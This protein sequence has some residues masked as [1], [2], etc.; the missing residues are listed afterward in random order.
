MYINRYLRHQQEQ[1]ASSEAAG[2]EG[3]EGTASEAEEA[4]GAEG[5]EGTAAEAPKPIDKFKPTHITCTDELCPVCYQDM[6][7]PEDLVRCPT[8][9]NNMHEECINI[10][11][12]TGKST[13][14]MCRS[15]VWNEYLREKKAELPEHIYTRTYTNLYN[16]MI[17]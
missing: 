2:A 8:C 6:E 10:W 4:A 15:E 1:G 16:L 13:C 11:F 17:G 14:V 5:A 7:K 9:K 12:R 3:T